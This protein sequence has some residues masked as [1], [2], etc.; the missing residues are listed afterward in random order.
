MKRTFSSIIVSMAMILTGVVATLHVTTPTASAIAPADCPQSFL[1]F[2]VWYRGLI[3]Q[4]STDCSLAPPSDPQFNPSG[5]DA[6]IGTYVGIIALNVIEM[7]LQLIG[8]IAAFFILYG[9]FIYLTQS[10]E[11]SK[12]EKARK[13][14]IGA[15]V[16][17]VISIFSVAIVNLIFSILT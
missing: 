8:Y 1:T 3:D 15:A 6:G 12:I 17:L 13:T 16:G 10:S 9:G 5:S 11:A 7:V 4:S 14:I 2:P